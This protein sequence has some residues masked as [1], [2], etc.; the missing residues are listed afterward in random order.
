MGFFVRYFIPSLIV[1]GKN[2]KKFSLSSTPMASVVYRVP[3]LLSLALVPGNAFILEIVQ[4]Q[5][6]YRCLYN[7]CD[8]NEYMFVFFHLDVLSLGPYLWRLTSI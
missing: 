5:T 3:G 4:V 8:I 1:A 6:L 7:R 2:V